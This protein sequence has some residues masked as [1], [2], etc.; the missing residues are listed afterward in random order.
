MHSP[1]TK[2]CSSGASSGMTAFGRTNPAI[3]IS[4]SA[5]DVSGFSPFGGREA[6]ITLEKW[7]GTEMDGVGPCPIT[8]YV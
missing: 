7:V 3:E 1:G 5:V 4:L 8:S 6:R 2:N